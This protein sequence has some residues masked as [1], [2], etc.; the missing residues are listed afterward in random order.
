MEPFIA[1][2]RFFYEGS[3]GR[4]VE[5]EAVLC[6]PGNVFLPLASL[7]QIIASSSKNSSTPNFDRAFCNWPE[8]IMPSRIRILV[9]SNDNISQFGGLVSAGYHHRTTNKESFLTWD[10]KSHNIPVFEAELIGLV[11]NSWAL[12]IAAAPQTLIA[13]SAIS[14]GL[15][16]V[17]PWPVTSLQTVA[18]IRKPIYD[19]VCPP[20]S[21]SAYAKM[22]YQF[23]CMN[24]RHDLRLKTVGFSRKPPTISFPPRPEKV[25]C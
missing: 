22:R 24:H 16:G 14:D 18:R 21:W 17:L 15:R 23:T 9:Y 25:D 5:L 6:R 11:S 13:A 12:S 20:E 7:R 8:R 4:E 1:G 2:W 3:V 19:C 10:F